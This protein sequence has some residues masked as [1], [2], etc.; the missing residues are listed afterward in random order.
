MFK[1]D[2]LAVLPVAQW[3]QTAIQWIA[4]NLRPIFLVIK[5]PIQK[6]LEAN[7]D[8]LHAVP[9]P[10]F[11]LVCAL[12]VWRVAGKAIAAFTLIGLVVI[13]VLGV[14][15]DAITTIALIVTAI[16]FCA[17]IGIPVGVACARSERVWR[18]VQPILDIMQTTPTFVYL[19]PVV[20][21]FGVGTVPGEVA[22]VIAAMPPLIRF[23]NL[24]IRMVD[25]ELVE[26][27]LAFGAD[28]RQLLWEVQ[29]PLA[30]P[31]ILGG[32]NQTV[33]T[34]MVMSVVISMIG[35]EGLGLVVLQGLGRLD[36]GQ[37]AI[38]G[39]AIVL[40]AMM[41]D[42]VTQKLARSQPGGGAL[43]DAMA[44][45]IRGGRGDTAGAL[46]E[47]RSPKEAL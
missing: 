46:P 31:T 6:L 27:G 7:I 19:V 22:V 30:V 3:I 45:L 28:R 18:I 36:V 42:R 9:F 24:G 16:V 43:R 32:L 11:V 1:A 44:R 15:S 33:L 14:W 26:A 40:L 38:G 2:D 8:A 12:V 10:I 21:L 17:V 4:L 41:L 29:L 20:M 34:A 5:W 37:A 39:I 23:T 13:A 35:A 25:H 47:E